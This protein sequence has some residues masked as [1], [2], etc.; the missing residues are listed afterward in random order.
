MLQQP[1]IFTKPRIHFFLNNISLDSISFLRFDVFSVLELGSDEREFLFFE[2]LTKS[3][4]R[5]I[6]DMKY[7]TVYILL[8]LLK[9]IILHKVKLFVYSVKKYG[10]MVT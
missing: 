7:E 6:L 10:R 8:N 4:F 5:L 3:N 9:Q 2:Y 1:I